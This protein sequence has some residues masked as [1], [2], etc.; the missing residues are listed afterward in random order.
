MLSQVTLG[1]VGIILTRL[2]LNCSDWYPLLDLCGYKHC[3]IADRDSVYDPG[4]M[5]GRL[6]LGL[7][8]QLAEVELNTIR[9]RMTAGLLNKEQWG[10]L[11][12]QLPMGLKHDLYGHVQKDPNL[13]VQNFIH[14]TSVLSFHAI[15]S[16]RL[17]AEIFNGSM[18]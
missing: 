12:M 14:L 8:G 7:K 17:M 9:I 2:S 5:N 18:V 6:L 3:L 13:E 11:K 15:N 4:T 1:H 10:D 16:N